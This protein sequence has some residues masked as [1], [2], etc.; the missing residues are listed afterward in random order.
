MIGQRE[1]ALV[2][3]IFILLEKELQKQSQV[4]GSF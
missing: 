1:K 3:L 4:K 2:H